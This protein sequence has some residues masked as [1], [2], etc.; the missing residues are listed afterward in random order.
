MGEFYIQLPHAVNEINGPIKPPKGIVCIRCVTKRRREG[1][2][3][4]L[5][6]DSLRANGTGITTFVVSAD[7]IEYPRQNPDL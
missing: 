4:R 2:L 6:F 3:E 7:F 5:P 1:N